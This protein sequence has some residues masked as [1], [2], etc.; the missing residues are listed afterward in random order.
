MSLD[1]ASPKEEF[2]IEYETKND[3][4]VSYLA[5][6]K[7]LTFLKKGNDIES[8]DVISALTDRSKLIKKIPQNSKVFYDEINQ[9][10]IINL[11]LDAW[12]DCTAKETIL[13]NTFDMPDFPGH[14]SNGEKYL[15]QKEPEPQE[16]SMSEDEKPSDE[17]VRENF[18]QTWIWVTSETPDGRGSITTK[19]PDSITTWLITGFSLNKGFGFA[20]AE[21]QELIVSKEFFV[22]LNLPYSLRFGEILKLEVIVFNFLRPELA[23]E[24]NANLK[25]FS[26]AKAEKNE[27][28]IQQ[29]EFLEFLD[30]S[31]SCKTKKVNSLTINTSLKVSHRT[32]S[33]YTTYIRP[34]IIKNIKI[35]AEVSVTIGRKT[36]TDEIVKTILVENEGIAFYNVQNTEFI[37]DEHN[38]IQSINLPFKAPDVATSAIELTAVIASDIMGPLIKFDENTL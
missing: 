31:L 24:I 10:F 20:L 2:T 6:D 28:F 8:S 33:R 17:T 23:G 37:L 26:M 1:R 34:K 19:I 14:S 36:F 18:P 12:R 11:N 9:N 32:G 38:K 4:V 29:F 30:L 15:S 7:S 35:R 21:P 22:E 16:I 25:I 3:S 13:L 5:F 27:D